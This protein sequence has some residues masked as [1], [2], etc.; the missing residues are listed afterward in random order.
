MRLM[1]HRTIRGHTLYREYGLPLRPRRV[2]SPM[3]RS[4]YDDL[5]E[6]LDRTMVEVTGQ[7]IG[8]TWSDI[9][10]IPMG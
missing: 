2:L 10:I 8:T 9:P 4:R 3:Y 5:V 6:R 7:R 1:L